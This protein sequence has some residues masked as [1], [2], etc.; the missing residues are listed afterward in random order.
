MLLGPPVNRIP[1]SERSEN[2]AQD[3]ARPVSFLIDVYGEANLKSYGNGVEI[4]ELVEQS[5]EDDNIV[6]G[7]KYGDHRHLDAHH[8]RGKALEPELYPIKTVENRQSNGIYVWHQ[9]EEIQSL[10]TLP[11]SNSTPMR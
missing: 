9:E 11:S 1:T 10:G 3:E 4:A 6:Y 7:H 5:V 2:D 8:R